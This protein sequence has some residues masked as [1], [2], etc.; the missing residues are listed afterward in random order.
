LLARATE[1]VKPN[2]EGR[3]MKHWFASALCILASLIGAKSFAAGVTGAGL[4][5]VTVTARRVV[6]AGEPRAASEGTVLAEQLENRPL[7]RVGELLE[8]VFA[9]KTLRAH[10]YRVRWKRLHRSALPSIM[11]RDG[12]AGFAFAI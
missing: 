11:H 2:D 5:E 3:S 10:A 9:T 7:L 8:V 12:S 6:L 4:E 1:T